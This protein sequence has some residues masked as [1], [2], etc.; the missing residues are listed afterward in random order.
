MKNSMYYYG[1]PGTSYK[2]MSYEEALNL[3]IT[4][5]HTHKR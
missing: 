5:A 1:I 3:K 2:N 4:S